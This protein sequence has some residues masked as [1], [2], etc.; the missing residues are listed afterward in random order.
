MWKN[1]RFSVPNRGYLLWILAQRINQWR[2]LLI[3]SFR[4]Q[5]G[6][7]I[8]NTIPELSAKN[9]CFR[10]SV[11]NRGYLLWIWKKHHK[12][13]IYRRCFRPQQGLL[14][15][16][17]ISG[18][19]EWRASKFPSP[20]GATYYECRKRIIREYQ[21]CVSVPNRGYLLWILTSKALINTT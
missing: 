16:N 6:L 9:G 17:L 5:Q 7:L 3:M 20:T 18:R 2:N 12:G 4:P 13:R 11:P 8:M 21:H 10:V 19:I 14:I 15:M 1:Y